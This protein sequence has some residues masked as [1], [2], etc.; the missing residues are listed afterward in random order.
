MTTLPH[1]PALGRPRRTLEEVK[2][3]RHQRRIGDLRH[4]LSR[5]GYCIA[6]IVALMKDCT[7]TA[8]YDEYLP[9]GFVVKKMFRC[10]RDNLTTAKGDWGKAMTW[11]AQDAQHERD[12]QRDF[13]SDDANEEF[14]H[15]KGARPR[16]I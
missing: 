6:D 13:C 3:E 7:D 12:S 11:M 8:H 4:A 15:R 16:V 2:R 5:H 1:S 10:L 14:L 9:R